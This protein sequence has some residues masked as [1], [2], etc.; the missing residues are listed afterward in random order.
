M[1]NEIKTISRPVIFILSVAVLVG[2][3][4]GLS[5]ISLMGLSAW[6]IASAALQPPLYVLSLAIV[7]VRFCGIMRAVFRYLE[8]YLSHKAGFALFMRFRVF[9][10]AKIIAALPF[11][12]Q[13]SN[14]DVFTIIVEAI[15]KIRDSFLRFF[16]PPITATLGC[17][18][19]M[20]WS[21]FYSVL[22]LCILFVAWLVFVV[23]M[24]MIVWRLYQKKSDNDLI[25]AESVLEFY[26]GSKELYAYNYIE[27]KLKN[28]Q[29]AI[30]DYQ[31]YR[32]EHFIL[33]S[34]VELSCEILLGLF[35]VLVLSLLISFI[36]DGQITAVM[37]ITFLLTIQSVLE[38]LAAIPSLMEHLDEAKRSWLSLKSFINKPKIQS[39]INS[40]IYLK[41]DDA[42]LNVVNINFGYNEILCK[43]MSFYLYKGQKTLFVGSSGCGK[44]TLFYVLTRLLDVFSGDMYLQGKSYMQW[45][46]E[47]W[48][49]HFAVSFQEHH[50]F[51]MS[52]RDNFKIF[53][54]D[55]SD[56]EIWQALDKV[57]FTAFV[58]QY[59]LDYVLESDGTNLSGGQKHRLQLA[60][61]LARKKDIILLDEPTAGLDI[62]SA[63]KF[64][65]RL[66]TIDKE[67]A[68]LVASHDLSIVDYFDNIIIM[69]EQHIIE[70]GKIKSLM[71]DEQSQLFKLMKYNNLI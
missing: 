39:K 16:L 41:D 55:I 28:T 14:G 58:Q 48:R 65:N 62:V 33:K 30:N 35:I 3:L 7:G 1:I 43:D 63:H 47:D 64:L 68:I 42:I 71:Q 52:I 26:D 49:N 59:G 21:G 44:S 36:N 23:I 61:C 17:F 4:A 57:Q 22:L 2:T 5:S 69:E 32:K 15:D 27:G 24:P 11:K 37:A 29:Q 20:I 54:P 56:E 25:L 66:I 34:K 18:I 13:S 12:R 45:D 51:N 50:I 53:Y 38:I 6:L 31:D 67:S 19:V 9:M 60:M 8:R 70:Q 40:N 10:L 46:K